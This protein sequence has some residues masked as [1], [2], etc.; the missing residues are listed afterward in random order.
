MATAPFVRTRD[1]ATF[2]LSIFL[3]I[4]FVYCQGRYP[5]THFYTYVTI[6]TPSLLMIRVVS[7]L[8]VR[9]YHYYLLD[10]CY[11]G[12][13]IMLLALNVYRKDEA[14]LRMAF[15]YSNGALA[16]SIAA[17]RNS[18]VLH[19][20][21]YLVSLVIH[22]VPM[23]TMINLKWGTLEQ[24][25]LLP[26]SERVFATMTNFEE[27]TWAEYRTLMLWNPCKPYLI[28]AAIY[29]VINFYLRADRIKQRNYNTL[30]SYL[31]STRFLGSCLTK[32]GDSFAPVCFMLIHFLFMIIGNVVAILAFHYEYFAYVAATVWITFAIKNGADFYMDYFARKYESELGDLP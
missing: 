14:V 18:L 9:K 16:I 3:I 12:N 30:F 1:K 11:V 21:D 10:F 25:K 22:A 19:R 2:V 8:A 15:L 27:Q 31:M 13:A 28:W 23:L 4:I 24:E 17:F 5:N 20:I 32:F 29:S 6:S 26:E 7:W